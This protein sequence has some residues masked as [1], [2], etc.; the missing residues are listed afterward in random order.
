MLKF[1]NRN[2][3]TRWEICPKLIIKIPERR[4]LPRSDVFIVNLT[5]FTRYSSVSIVDF[6]QVN[7][8]QEP[9]LWISIYPRAE[10]RRSTAAFIA[11]ISHLVLMFLLLILSMHLIGGFDVSYFSRSQIKTNPSFI[12]YSFL[13]KISTK[14]N[15]HPLAS[16]SKQDMFITNFNANCSTNFLISFLSLDN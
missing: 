2:T 13:E 15:A 14:W 5:Y 4:Y 7:V 10:R 3:R 16:S 9:V 1:H 11:H 8:C 6:E 12:V